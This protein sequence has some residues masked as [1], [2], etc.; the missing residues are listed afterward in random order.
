M[1]IVKYHRKHVPLVCRDGFRRQIIVETEFPR[2]V[3]YPKILGRPQEKINL[4]FGAGFQVEMTRREA[5]SVAQEL[6]QNFALA[7]SHEAANKKPTTKKPENMEPF[8]AAYTE[9]LKSEIPLA[10]G[11]GFTEFD[12][13]SKEKIRHDCV[14]FLKLAKDHLNGQSL[15][16]V[17][18]VFHSYRCGTGFAGIDSASLSQIALIAERQF[19]PLLCRV[20]A[21][22]TALEVLEA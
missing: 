4:E 21:G 18:A 16:K 6:I 15:A 9:R 14:S 17:V 5:L 1:K 22:R 10:A 3:H 20:N 8:I 2:V 7:E 12:G 13:L 19:K 11:L